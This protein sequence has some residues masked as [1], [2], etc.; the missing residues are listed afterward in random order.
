[1]FGRET[2]REFK[3]S[4]PGA[5]AAPG[6]PIAEC[7]FEGGLN[8]AL[9]SSFTDPKSAFRSPVTRSLPLPVPFWYSSAVT[10]IPKFGTARAAERARIF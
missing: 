9:L 2:K 7:G 10:S 5:L 8:T 1:L 4:E 3:R 6:K